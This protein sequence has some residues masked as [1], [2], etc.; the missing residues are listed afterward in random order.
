MITPPASPS[1]SIII[2]TLN[3][4]KYLPLLLKDLAEQTFTN[5]EVILVDGNSDDKTVELAKEFSDKLRLKIITSKKR[6]VAH[7]RN[8]GGDAA[9][10]QWLIFFDA[11]NRLPPYLLQGVRYQ[12]DKN[13]DTD[14]FTCWMKP[15]SNLLGDVSLVQ[16]FNLSIEVS[17]LIKNYSAFGAFIGVRK[18]IFSK[19]TFNESIRVLEDTVFVRGLA[20]KGFVFRIFK[21]P[22]Y[23]VSLRRVRKEGKLKSLQVGAVL[24]FKLLQG[25]HFL[26]DDQIYPMLG[27]TYHEKNDDL[28]ERN[29][30]STLSRLP[31]KRLEEM[32][33]IL[34][35]LNHFLAS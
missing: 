23:T 25:E 20:K 19:H 7:Q 18:S 26:T 34:D 11:D 3:E 6:N 8:L 9:L 30:R 2:P 12:L 10:A 5:F 33:K 24:Q 21:D 28:L 35:K 13:P 14:V 4:E 1:F 32:K 17:F 31:K 27:G 15:D 29:I 22:K 16:S